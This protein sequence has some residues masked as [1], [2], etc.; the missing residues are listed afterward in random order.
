MY[1]VFTKFDLRPIQSIGC[2]VRCKLTF[3]N[4]VCKGAFSREVKEAQKEVR[5]SQVTWGFS[6]LPNYSKKVGYI[7]KGSKSLVRAFSQPK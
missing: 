6:S 4:K 7:D 3:K 2:D 1:Q 5:G